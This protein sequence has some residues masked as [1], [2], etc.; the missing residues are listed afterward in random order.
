MT[1]D[2]PKDL[3]DAERAR[4]AAA[5]AAAGDLRDALESGDGNDR[6]A[7]AA[8]LMQTI[9]QLDPKATLDK[10]HIPDDA[11]RY[12]AA[13]RT[14]LA[15]IPE[16]WGRWISCDRGWFPIVV[17]LDQELAAIDPRYQLLQVKEKFGGAAVLLPCISR[18]R[19][20][21]QDPDAR[22]GRRSRTSM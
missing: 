18:R 11:G 6:T 10:L 2:H 4:Y 8:A 1:D 12:E 20:V 9:G 13:L 21:H 22:I 14:I 5:R 19:R 7:A 16:G 17:D 3:T 15:R